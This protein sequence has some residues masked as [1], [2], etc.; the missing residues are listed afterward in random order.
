[1][2][3][4]HAALRFLMKKKDAKQRLIRWVLLLQEFDLELKDKSG[5]ENTVADHLSKL[6]HIVDGEVVGDSFPDERLL[7]VTGSEPW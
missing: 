6:E 2:F 4:D 1:M 5:L 7:Q 3:T